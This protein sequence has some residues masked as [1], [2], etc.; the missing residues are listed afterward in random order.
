MP[1]S[2]SASER[3]D[4]WDSAED[5]EK[6]EEEKVRARGERR[7]RKRRWNQQ[8]RRGRWV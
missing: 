5:A 8:A 3:V 2:S 4:D 6:E 1:S 7:R